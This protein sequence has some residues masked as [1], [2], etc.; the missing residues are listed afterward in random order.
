MTAGVALVGAALGVG[1]AAALIPVMRHQLTAAMARSAEGGSRVALS[2][3]VAVPW[4]RAILL[5]VSGALPAVVLARSG[6]SVLLLPLLFLLLGLVQLAYCDMTE[7]L[8]PR[9]MVH[10]TTI[11]VTL[12][13]LG[14][15]AWTGEWH[16]L[17]VAAMGGAALFV[18]LF[19]INMMNS[20]WMAFGDV[21]LAPAVGVGLAWIGPGAL[22]RGF[23]FANVLAAVVG[24]ALM[25]ARKGDRRTALPFGL[26]LAIASAIV[27]LQAT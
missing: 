14:A 1:A 19:A 4:H 5:V 27:I 26:Y 24:L 9:P 7:F 3:A 2:P 22:V 17:A 8:L 23:F 6:W 15:A 13:A 12:S 18:L 25:A 11:V 21:R 20:A 10:A 16:R